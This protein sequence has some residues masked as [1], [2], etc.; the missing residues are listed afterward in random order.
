MEKINRH[1]TFSDPLYSINDLV[2]I[3][4]IMLVA[5]AHNAIYPSTNTNYNKV[6]YIYFQPEVRLFYLI[7]S[8][9]YYSANGTILI[10]HFLYQYFGGFAASNVTISSQPWHELN[11]DAFANQS[12]T[13]QPPLLLLEPIVMWVDGQV[14]V[15]L[16]R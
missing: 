11:L 14:K 1:K 12:F 9:V 2:N 10:S 5:A 15:L 13:Y 8:E 3:V 6:P 16:V 4:N 7:V